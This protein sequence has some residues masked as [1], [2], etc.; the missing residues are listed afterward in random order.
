[1]DNLLNCPKNGVHVIS[2]NARNG[3]DFVFERAT[4]VSGRE[5]EQQFDLVLAR[6]ACIGLAFD[7]ELLGVLASQGV[8]LLQVD[9]LQCLEFVVL[10]S[11]AF[12]VA[13]CNVEL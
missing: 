11:D 1:M 5:L 7:C 10:L 13:H 6:F 12:D 3:L 9:V 8:E 2:R 4:R